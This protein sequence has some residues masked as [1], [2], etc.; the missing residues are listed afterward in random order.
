M[1]KK[2]KYVFFQ[3]IEKYYQH[4][5][6]KKKITREIWVLLFFFWII[7]IIIIRLIQLQIVE[8]NYYENILNAQHFSQSLLKA[9]R[10]N[11][12]VTDNSWKPIKL[13]ENIEFFNIFVDP[14]YINKDRLIELIAPIIYEHFCENFQVE[15][16][17]KEQCIQNIEWFTLEKILPKDPEIFYYWSWI[18]TPWFFWTGDKLFDFTWFNA[19]KMSI[20]SWF[21]K[22]KGLELIKK[23]LDQ[24]IEVWIK[25]KNYVWLFTN[26]AIGKQIKEKNLWYIEFQSPWYVR[27][28]PSKITNINQSARTIQT[29]LSNAWFDISMERIINLLKPQENRYIRI[30]TDVNPEIA[31][32]IRELK[33]QYFNE[34]YNRTPILHGLWLEQYTRRYYPYWKF[35]SNTLWFV[36]KNDIS[37][38][39]IEKFFDENLKG[40]D[41][42]IIG[43]ASAW[44]WWSDFSIQ[45]A[46]DGQDIYLTIDPA[47]Q[48]ETEK[49]IDTYQR[50]FRADSVSVMI[51]DPY[52]GKIISSAN[53][54]TFNPNNIQE[55]FKIKPL[56]KNEMSIIDDETYVDVPVFIATWWNIKV[57]TTAERRDTTIPKYISQ[58][59]FWAQ[60]FIDKNIA[61]P[62]EPWSIIKAI[63]LWIGIDNDE[64]ELYDFYDDK[65][66]VE[67]IIWENL[68]YT[69]K[70]VD[71]QCIWKNTFLHAL[72]FSCNVWMIR[73]VQKVWKQ[74][75]YNYLNKLWFGKPTWIELYGE[76]PWFVEDINTISLSRFLNNAF[77][78]WLLATPIQILQAYAALIN[79]W[80]L[81]KPTIIDKIYNP[82]T[83]TFQ[84]NHPQIIQQV[85]K[86]EL[87]EDIKEALF[88]TIDNTF[89]KRFSYMSWYT[90][91]WKSWTSQIS[92]KGRYKNWLWRTNGSFVWIVTKENLKYIISVQVR[93]PRTNLWWEATAWKIFHDISQFI[94]NYHMIEK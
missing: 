89:V 39:G 48:K 66:K 61:F 51:M 12:F 57:A 41:W 58:N 22:E 65:W 18:F 23:R 72:Q 16:P 79:W 59:I 93:R 53:A 70:N 49:I 28:I 68:T 32:K 36:D 11:I 90:L 43:R 35:L 10:W 77:W 8:W 3:T 78:Q 4:I 92:F 30:L 88:R 27:I 42:R 26:E 29:I 5:T 83:Q 1:T 56:W 19:E 81:V 45:E 73:I 86:P 87:A 9:K 50:L 6:G 55:A 52:N 24:R 37:F 85:F 17:S 38:Y 7:F 21:N 94:I 14:K 67:I 91:W 60:V 33:T 25:E 63:T 31:K 44:V 47:I 64:I 15:K 71:E 75:Y 20:I 34:T 13:T 84:E 74:N 62:Y 46:I 82:I 80:Y 69:I 54:P 2:K 76:E 40:K